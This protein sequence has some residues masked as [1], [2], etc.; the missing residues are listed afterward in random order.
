MNVAGLDD[1]HHRLRHGERRNAAQQRLLRR[2]WRRARRSLTCSR[3]EE[4]IYILWIQNYIFFMPRVVVASVAGSK[5]NIT[6]QSQVRYPDGD[7]TSDIYVADMDK[8]A[9]M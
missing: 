5:V 3:G 6:M 2:L 4:N 1:V 9:K 8:I 7:C